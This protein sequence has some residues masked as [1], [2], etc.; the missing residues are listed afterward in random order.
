MS[1]KKKKPRIII[2]GALNGVFVSALL[3][4]DFDQFRIIPFECCY[5]RFFFFLQMLDE[6]NNI[7]TM[8]VP[9]ERQTKRPYSIDQF[10]GSPIL[11]QWVKNSD[12]NET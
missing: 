12:P 9:T 7:V 10:N 5:M 4:N 3:C 8:N 11:R 6:G 2:Y 1:R